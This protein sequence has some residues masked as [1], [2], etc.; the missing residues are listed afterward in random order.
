VG[1]SLAD[2]GMVGVGAVGMGVRV[3]VVGVM[4]MVPPLSGWQADK[5][6]VRRIIITIRIE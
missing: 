5:E 6:S 4:I 2:A 3:G 1:I